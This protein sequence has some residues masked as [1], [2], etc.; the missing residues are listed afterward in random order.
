MSRR[1]GRF[2]GDEFYIYLEDTPLEL[3]KIQL[4]KT[5]KALTVEYS[6][7]REKIVVAAS[8]GS[9]YCDGSKDLTFVDLVKLADTATYQAKEQGKNGYAIKMA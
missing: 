8:I 4:E 9:V 7:N 5:N 6:N 1:G 3:L 2:G